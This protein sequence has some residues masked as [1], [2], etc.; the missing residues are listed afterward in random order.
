MKLGLAV[1]DQLPILS[2]KFGLSSNSAL[3]LVAVVGCLLILTVIILVL[4]AAETT[5][6]AKYD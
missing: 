6:H 2:E 3:F 1:K 4:V 5:S